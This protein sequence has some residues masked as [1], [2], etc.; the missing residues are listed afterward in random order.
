MAV[1][2]ALHA[3]SRCCQCLRQREVTGHTVVS[4]D[5]TVLL[6]RRHRLPYLISLNCMFCLLFQ[7]WDSAFMFL[8][9]DRSVCPT[10]QFLRASEEL[11]ENNTAGRLFIVCWS[12]NDTNTK[13]MSSGISRKGAALCMLYTC[14]HVLFSFV[15]WFHSLL[16]HD[17]NS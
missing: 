8:V 6:S 16:V 15:Y 12:E 11:S 1:M 2:T 7:I 5:T 17:R 4:L 13:T 10:L 14:I 9:S 3:L